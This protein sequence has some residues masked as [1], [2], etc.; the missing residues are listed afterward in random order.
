M[1]LIEILRG[2]Q[3]GDFHEGEILETDDGMCVVEVLADHR[4]RVT[5]P[6]NRV[7][8]WRPVQNLT[9]AHRAHIQ[10]HAAPGG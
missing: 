6:T 5:L 2:L 9:H 8:F 3:N 1:T 4:L 7:E 10:P